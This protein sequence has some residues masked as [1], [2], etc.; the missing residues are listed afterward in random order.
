M[1]S[2]SFFQPLFRLHRV[3]WTV[4]NITEEVFYRSDSDGLSD[5]QPAV[6]KHKGSKNVVQMTV[7][8]IR[9]EEAARLI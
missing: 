6:S 1:L 5:G 3:N 7:G 4:S 2:D 9:H 8:V